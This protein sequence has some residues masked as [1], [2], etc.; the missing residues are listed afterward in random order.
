MANITQSIL[1][2]IRNKYQD[3]R[4]K[5]TDEEGWFRGNNFTPLRQIE[6]AIPG[7]F[8]GARQR[9]GQ[10]SWKQYTPMQMGPDAV[11]GAEILGTALGNRQ[12]GQDVGYF[13]KGATNLTPWGMASKQFNKE[14]EALVAPTTQRQKNIQNLGESVYGIALTAPLGGGNIVTNIGSRAIQGT[15]LGTGMKLGSN[16]LSGEKW[17]KD[18]GQ[19]AISGLGNSWKLAITNS[20]TD[21]V[22]GKVLPSLTSTSLD[23]GGKLLKEAVSKGSPAAKKIFVNNAIKLFGRALAEVPAENTFY[24]LFDKLTGEE[25]RKFIDAWIQELPGNVLGNLAF[26]GLQV[27]KQGAYDLN[28]P[29]IDAAANAFIKTAKNFFGEGFQLRPAKTNL[30]TT[31]G[32]ETKENVEP[33]TKVEPSIKGGELP[34]KTEEILPQKTITTS[35]GLVIKVPNEPKV[36]KVTTQGEIVNPRASGE[37]SEPVSQPSTPRMKTALLDKKI[38]LGFEAKNPE[39]KLPPVES[40]MPKLQTE[41]PTTNKPL[42]S[43]DILPLPQGEVEQQVVRNKAQLKKVL[44][45]NPNANVRIELKPE[46]GKITTYGNIPERGDVAATIPNRLDGFISNVLGYSTKAPKGGTREAGLW[47]RTL[48][49]GQEAITTK[50]EEG[51]GSENSIIRTAASTLQNFFKGLGMS[52]E[53]AKASAELRGEMGVANQRAYDVMET[54]YESIGHNKKS[55]ERIN[56]VL[57]PSVSKIKI[58]FDD[59]TKKEKQ[60]YGLI[61]EGLDL[62]HD[63]SYANGHISPELY[64]ANKSKYVPRLYDVT[65]LPPEVNQFVTQ[66]KKIVNNLYKHRKDVDAW[67][68]DNSLNDPVYALGKRLSQ[69]ETNSAIKKYTD[70]LANNER[71]ISD[72]EKPGF[73]KLSDSPAYGALSGKWVMNSAAEDLKGFFFSNQAMQNLYDVFRAYDRMPIRQLQKKLLTVFNPTTNVG[74]VVSDQVFGFLTGIDPLTLNKNLLN[75]KENPATFKKLNDYLIRQGIT[76]TDIT[77]TDFVNKLASI[78]ELAKGRKDGKLKL[79]TNK[80]QKFYGGTDDAYKIAALKSLL[81]KGFTLEEATRKVA[82]GFQN[83]SNVG[84][85]YDLASKTPIIGKP[86]I[87]FQGDLIRIIKNGVVNNPLGLITFLG[88]LKGISYLSSKL[89][90]E[91]DEDRKTRENRFA[92][93][94]IPGL[95]IPLTWQTPIGEINIARY[96]SPFYANNETTNI[97]SDVF[98]FVPNIDREKDVASNIALNVN[99]P[100]V[101]PLIQLAVNRDFR[102]K[103]ISDPEENKYQPSTLTPEEKLKNQAIFLGR[104]YTPPPVNSAIDVAQV[105]STGKNMYGTPQTVGQSIARL[106]GIKVSQY[107]PEEIQAIRDKDAE[108]QQKRNESIN[109]QINSVHKQALKGE[110]T[111]QQEEERILNL[112]SQQKDVQINPQKGEDI[113]Y[114]D[115]DGDMR[116]IGISKVISMPEDSAYQRAIKEQK[117]YT[118][119]DDIL[120]NLEPEQQAQALSQLGISAEEAT[121]YNVAKQTNAIKA[122][123]VEEEIRRLIE[124]GANKNDVLT[125]MAKWRKSINGQILLSNG[126]IDDLV[127]NSIISYADG[128]LLK[129]IESE[130][131]GRLRV[132]SS[133]P[134]KGKKISVGIKT[135]TPIKATYTP[136]KLQVKKR[137]VKKAIQPKKVKLNFTTPKTLL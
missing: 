59:L 113:R 78:D 89:T 92:A 14:Q 76:R 124:N 95:N 86:F 26:A 69:V 28:K 79:L 3:I 50:V 100:L 64:V 98:P 114:I 102:G 12:A 65:E 123:F 40:P 55:L 43:P 54:L 74:N 101:S 58:S 128:K 36:G 118:L 107:G 2:S 48:R 135:V 112:K 133:A 73:T 105:V 37:V 56:A 5:M 67:K 53:R 38:D 16:I 94:M 20:V 106:G 30:F 25:K 42:P 1:N 44:A 109:K 77:R 87:K 23:T 72:V 122:I 132:K 91:S 116:T 60:V 66:G 120:D 39:V 63:I 21:K 129:Q 104:A 130:A 24:V 35:S 121:Y 90:G 134:K 125:Q 46:T 137:V 10:T 81:D 71:F 103:P 96:I 41:L 51:M 47:T 13:F 99:D 15:V 115:E 6:T 11:R 110:I 127:D 62:V 93:P 85:F 17:N 49:K 84:K 34:V 75:L 80:V 111:P 108:Y 18:L 61:R 19:G 117:K 8:E 45:E 131:K 83:Y 32:P 88:T 136:I 7:G 31:I 97:A 33:S 29:Q 70:F 52:P 22:L 9:L 4:S 57:D 68:I 27:G 82:D 119:V 126:V